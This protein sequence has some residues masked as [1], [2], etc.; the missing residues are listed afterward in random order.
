MS[1][2]LEFNFKDATYSE[3]EQP[4]IFNFVGNLFKVLGGFSND[5]ISI[6]AD[7]NATRSSFKIYVASKG[8]GAALSV[9]DLSSKMLVDFYTKTHAGAFNEEL[10]GEDVEDL[11]V[12]SRG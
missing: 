3:P 9:V 6:V 12:G 7:E 5:F 1:D 2:I 10:G 8:A 4:L 11:N